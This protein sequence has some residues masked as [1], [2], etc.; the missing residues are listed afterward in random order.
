M[1]TP[2]N[3]KPSRLSVLATIM[4]RIN[5]R[6]NIGRFACEDD[7]DVNPVQF[8]VG[9]DVEGSSLSAKQIHTMVDAGCFAFRYYEGVLAAIAF[10]SQSADQVWQTFLE[11]EKSKDEKTNTEDN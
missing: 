9:F 11:E 7:G 4:N 5:N 2:F 3:I 6:L 10:T 1:Y 8:K